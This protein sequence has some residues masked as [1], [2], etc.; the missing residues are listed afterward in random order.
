MED[1]SDDDIKIVIITIIVVIIIALAVVGV[2]HL[3]EPK[4]MMLFVPK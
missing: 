4:P 1:T 3:L 2:L